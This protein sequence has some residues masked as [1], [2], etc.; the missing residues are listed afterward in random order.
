MLSCCLAARLPGACSAWSSPVSLF[1]WAAGIFPKIG[2]LWCGCGYGFCQSRAGVPRRAGG[3]EGGGVTGVGVAVVGAIQQRGRGG[4]RCN[5]VASKTQASFRTDHNSR[6]GSDMEA[7][8][9]E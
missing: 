6:S 1:S 4:A 8:K 3:V 2:C 7:T 5:D 9:N